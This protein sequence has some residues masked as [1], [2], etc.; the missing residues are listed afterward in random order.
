MMTVTMIRNVATSGD[1]TL[2]HVLDKVGKNE[3][4]FESKFMS[5]HAVRC[6]LIILHNLFK[7]LLLGSKAKT[8]LAKQH[9]ARKMYRLYRKM[10]IYG[11]F[12]I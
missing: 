1:V 6:L 7:T 9:L 4:H 8:V 3:D 10:A 5:C 11:H 2:K 12:F